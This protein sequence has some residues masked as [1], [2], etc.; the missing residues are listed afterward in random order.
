MEG[1]FVASCRAIAYLSAGA[2]IESGYSR[3]WW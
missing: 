3:I 1:G 2:A